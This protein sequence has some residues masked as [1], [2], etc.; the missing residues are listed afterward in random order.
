MVH[1]WSTFRSALLVCIIVASA[2]FAK[3]QDSFTV[4]TVIS[5]VDTSGGSPTDAEKQLLQQIADKAAEVARQQYPMI[6][7]T[8]RAEHNYQCSKFT[9]TF[10][11]G[12]KGVAATGNDHCEVSA[13]YAL[14]H[15][16]DIPGVIVHELTHVVQHYTHKSPGWLVEGIAD[17]VRWY[18]YEPVSKRHT[19]HASRANYD[20]SYQTT[21]SFLDWAAHKYNRN[22]V[23]FLNQE[24]YEGTYTDDSWTKLT[25]HTVGQLN[26]EW[27]EVL[28]P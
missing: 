24:L 16:D 27:K 12:Y 3:A 9:I 10:T 11:Y 22:L 6:V 25:G 8:L 18:N 26:A 4:P 28:P 5:T 19:P 7:R 14:R 21:A 13:D 23:K 20:G 17:F 1:N 15:P 2:S